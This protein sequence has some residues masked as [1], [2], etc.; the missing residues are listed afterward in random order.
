MSH[1]RRNDG[2]ASC[3]A[4]VGEIEA[5]ADVRKVEANANADARNVEAVADARKAEAVMKQRGF[6]TEVVD[7]L[8]G[9]CRLIELQQQSQ[10]HKRSADVC[11]DDRWL[12]T[13]ITTPWSNMQPLSGAIWEGRPSNC[14]MG[15]HDVL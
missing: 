5:S 14:T 8:H 11:I 13:K 4:I 1:T 7:R 9:K 15:L 6:E 3:G 10:S 12:E 2:T